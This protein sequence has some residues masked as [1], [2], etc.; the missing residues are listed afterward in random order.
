M[1]EI[2]VC[3]TDGTELP[4]LGRRF[5]DNAPPDVVIDGMLCDFVGFREA[6]VALYRRRPRIQESGARHVLAAFGSTRPG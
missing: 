1:V 2:V 6:G 4:E 5:H 3:D